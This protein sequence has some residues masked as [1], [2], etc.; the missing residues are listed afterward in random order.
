MGN[1]HFPFPY[2]GAPG[3]PKPAGVHPPLTRVASNPTFPSVT[4]PAP[5]SP[6]VLNEPPS[7]NDSVALPP[8]A[9]Q[10]PNMW[11]QHSQPLFSLANVI[12]MAMSMAQS[13]I[14]PSNLPAQGIPSFPSFHNMA[15]QS[16]YPSVYPH[17]QTAPAEVPYPA[18]LIPAQKVLHSP[19]NTPLMDGFPPSA[20]QSWLHVVSP[21]SMTSTPPPASLEPLQQPGPSCPP[22]P[23]QEALTPYSAQIPVQPE[24]TSEVSSLTSSSDLSPSPPDSPENTVSDYF[25]LSGQSPTE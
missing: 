2:P 7:I 21:P 15:P 14:P 6:R 25:L 3:S 17:Y 4:S 19:E 13:F 23:T 22:I 18:P 20:P 9:P 10:H 8:P 16:G 11:P 24:P 5:G 12:S 1:T